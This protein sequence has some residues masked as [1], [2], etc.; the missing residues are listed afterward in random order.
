MKKLL[1][2]ALAVIP[3]ALTSCDV[4]KEGDESANATVL[5][6]TWYFADSHHPFTI[7]FK[8]DTYTFETP[9]FKDT[10]T[11]TYKDGVIKC[12][13]QQRW[14]SETGWEGDQR[15]NIGEWESITI[16]PDYSSRTFEVTLLEKGICIGIMNDDFYGG[17]PWEMILICKGAKISIDASKLNGEWIYKE[18][19]ELRGRLIVDGNKYTVW[20]SYIF[21]SNQEVIKEFG[22]WSYADGYLT[23]SPDS[24]YFSYTYNDNARQYDYSPVDPQ[25]LEA[26]VWYPAQYEPDE[27]KIPA[28]LSNGTFY[29][30]M[31]EMTI[32]KF[33]KK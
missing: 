32:S 26:E 14:S 2:L 21:N 15:I 23:L 4:E 24:L 25:T 13:F 31:D 9:G 18:G 7:V 22:E 17:E 10:G 19:Q 33:T 29:I 30:M 6:G 8:G 5:E 1:Y 12:N 27:S 11:F 28:Y 20:E 16:D 3:F